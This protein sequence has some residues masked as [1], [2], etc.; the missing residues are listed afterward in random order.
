MRV[1]TTDEVRLNKEKIMREI[2]N[3]AL[4]IYPTD[5]IYGIGC[6]ATSSEAVK[7]LRALKS[8]YTMPF[9]VIAPSKQ[10]VCDN[11]DMKKNTCEKWLERF[12]GTYTIIVRLKNKKC[13]AKETNNGLDTLGIRIPD[14]WFSQIVAELKMPVITTS[15]N[16]VGGNYMTSMEDLDPK[17]KSNVSFII[18]EGEKKG[19]PS[20]L[21]DLTN[22]TEKIKER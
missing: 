8:R 4:F 2:R 22:N 19:R 20:K 15:A 16:F 14:H 11:C 3:G 6:D 9:S 13:I 7:K 17:I 12:P 21:I 1:Y 5:T 10:W 18:Y